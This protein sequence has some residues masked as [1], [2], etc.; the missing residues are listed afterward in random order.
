VNVEDIGISDHRQLVWSK[1]LQRPAPTYD[2]TNRR[3]WR[4]FNLELLQED[5]QASVL[6]DDRAW[7]DLDDSDALVQLYDDTIARLLDRQV[8]TEKKTCR[9][10]PSNIMV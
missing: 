2:T 4:L 1:S 7:R 5:V 10:R 3:P 9:R 6:C 8:P